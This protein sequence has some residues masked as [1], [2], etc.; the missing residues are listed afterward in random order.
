MPCLRVLSFLVFS[1]K[2]NVMTAKGD[3]AGRRQKRYE[4]R[5]EERAQAEA[6]NVTIAA[7]QEMAV[8]C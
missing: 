1:P 6:A 4:E 7:G 5:A 2:P 8:G 3:L